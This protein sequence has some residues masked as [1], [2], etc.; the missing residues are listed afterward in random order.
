VSAPTRPVLRYHGGKWRLAP[1]IIS[2]FP[3]HRIYTEAFGGAGSVLLRK[4]RA[5][6]VEVLND[7]DGEVVN[8]FRV[9]RDEQQSAQLCALL[10]R[11]PYA[12]AEFV[13]SYE[14]IAAPVEQAR[15]TVVRSFMGFGSD[16]ASGAVT[17]F[18]ANGNRQNGHP[19][20]DWSNYPLSLQLASERLRGVVIECRAGADV[21][22]QHDAPG[23]LHYVDPP[24]A[25]VTRSAHTLRKGKGYRHEMTDDDHRA[26]AEVLR[27]AEGMVVLSGYASDLY[28][29]ELYAGW[30]RRE[31]STQADG[32][33]ARTEVL[34]LNPAC[35]S[36]LARVEVG[37]A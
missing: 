2:H 18:R 28:D 5:P 31:K 35:C 34:W 33:R 23:T 37:A 17:G 11:T 6:F 29:S 20:R 30:D 26:L 16:S 15:R 14:V 4:P 12:R 7:L 36:A 27:A 1:W 13:D 24:Y 19:A 25:R 9:L 22:R 10:W 8:L 21:I 32:A 3:P